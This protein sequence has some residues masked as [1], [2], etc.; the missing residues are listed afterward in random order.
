MKRGYITFGKYTP[1]WREEASWEERR[2]KMNQMK[3][4]AAKQGFEII[5]WGSPYGIDKKVC[6]VWR[7][8]KT[9]DEYHKLPLDILPRTRLRIQ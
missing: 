1:Y 3:S 6:V 8:E 5:C 9:L 4:E 7:S 2:M